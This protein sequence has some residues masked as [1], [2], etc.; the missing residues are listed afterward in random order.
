MK[1]YR[2]LELEVR[3][4]IK[5]KTRFWDK[6]SNLIFPANSTCPR[7]GD[8]GELVHVIEGDGAHCNTCDLSIHAPTK[9]LNGWKVLLAVI[10]LMVGC[11]L[12]AAWV[13]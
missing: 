7:C 6:V 13:L 8:A 1:D 11:T 3:S 2:Y 9:A 4:Q 12:M 10:S 5:K